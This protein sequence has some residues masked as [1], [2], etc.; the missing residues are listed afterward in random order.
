MLQITIQSAAYPQYVAGCDT[1]TKFPLG[2]NSVLQNVGGRTLLA[3]RER[4]DDCIL[5]LSFKRISELH[6]VP[7][8]QLSQA[9]VCEITVGLFSQV[10]CVSCRIERMI[11]SIQVVLVLEHQI[12][13]KPADSRLQLVVEDEVSIEELGKEMNLATRVGKRGVGKALRTVYARR[14]AG[15]TE[16]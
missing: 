8:L 6:I 13:G 4:R 11:C 10:G 5:L 1:G 9:K 2:I 15:Q 3:L 7:V 16:A 14:N 12:Q